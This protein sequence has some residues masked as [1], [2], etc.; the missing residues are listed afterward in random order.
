MLVIQQAN[1]M[2]L[3]PGKS[4]RAISENVSE[5]MRS[6]YPQK[7]AVAAALNTARQAAERGGRQK[8]PKVFHGPLKAAIPGRTD[9]MPISVVSGSYVL[10][11]DCVSSLG[12][13]NTEAGFEVVKKMIEDAKSRGGR[14]GSLNLKS[15]YGINGPYHEPRA[16]VPCVVAG[17]EFILSPEE[18]ELFGD[19]NLDAGHKTLDAFVKKQR[20]KHIKVLRRLPPPAKD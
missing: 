2:P 8:N 7:Q 12:E 6:G 1:N 18:V 19:G 11:A 10:P 4:N 13:N 20:Q 3:K 16:I 15:K 5:M 14:V 9:R 17:G